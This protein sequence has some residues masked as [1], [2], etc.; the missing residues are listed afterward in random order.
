MICI[1]LSIS[2]SF[3]DSHFNALIFCIGCFGTGTLTK[4]SGNFSSPASTSIYSEKFCTWLIKCSANH[5]IELTFEFYTYSTIS[6]MC[7]FAYV[8]V[9]DGDSPSKTSLGRFCEQHWNKEIKSTGS[10]LYVTL[11]I[12]SRFRT[13]GVPSF[14]ATYTCKSSTWTKSHYNL[15]KYNSPFYETVKPANKNYPVNEKIT[16]ES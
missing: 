13:N 5:K 7:S 1:F 6:D 12:D 9:Y 2:L 11:W 8:E 3:S 14:F 10:S 4:L 16:S 15:P